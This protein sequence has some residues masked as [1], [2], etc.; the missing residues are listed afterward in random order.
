MGT[1]GR[2]E[3]VIGLSGNPAAVLCLAIKTF[4]EKRSDGPVRHLPPLNLLPAKQSPGIPP[5]RTWLCL[6]KGASSWRVPAGGEAVSQETWPLQPH[7]STHTQPM[8]ILVG[9][10]RDSGLQSGSALHRLLC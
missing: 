5:Y 3:L 2:W 10:V 4:L 6:G 9:W 8:L 7:L 1:C